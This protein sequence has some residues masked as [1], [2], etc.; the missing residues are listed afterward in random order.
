MHRRLLFFCCWLLFLDLCRTVNPD[1][2]TAWRRVE[3]PRQAE[4]SA[5]ATKASPT[6]SREREREKEQRSALTLYIYASTFSV[7]FLYSILNIVVPGGGVSKHLNA[8]TAE[9]SLRVFSRYNPQGGTFTSP[10]YPKRY[11]SRVDCLLYT[12]QGT[13][14]EIVELTFHHFDTRSTYPDCNRGDFL[15]V[16]L[17][18]EPDE[19]GVNEYTPWSGLLCG[20]LADIPQVLYSSGPTLI[21]EFHAEPSAK[22]TNVTSPGFSGNFRFIDK[23]RPK[24]I[25]GSYAPWRIPLDVR[26][27][28]VHTVQWQLARLSELCCAVE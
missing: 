24:N 14:D 3:Q 1:T 5:A 4:G 21:F 9:I 23:Q 20:T 12:F 11:P 25:K 27:H 15:K 2:R 19:R 7:S 6:R 22:K 28:I 18:L 16:F 13:A 10:D 8:K 26:A 17:H